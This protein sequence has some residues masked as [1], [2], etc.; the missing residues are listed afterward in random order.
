MVAIYKWDTAYEAPNSQDGGNIHESIVHERAGV[1]SS[2]VCA[3][4]NQV[5]GILYI[6]IQ[7]CTLTYLCVYTTQGFTHI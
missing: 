6:Y 3:G 2:S 1:I 7:S 4:V 5:V